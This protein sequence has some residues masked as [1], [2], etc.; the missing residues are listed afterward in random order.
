M[1]LNQ[2]NDKIILV[3]KNNNKIEFEFDVKPTTSF[4]ES[5]NNIII[6]L[7]LN[8]ED[9]EKICEVEEELKKRLNKEIK[10]VILKNTKVGIFKLYKVKNKICCEIKNKKNKNIL[11]TKLNIKKKYKVKLVLDYIWKYKDKFGF[12]WS[13]HH[14]QE[15]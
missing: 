13:I 2:I 11:Y 3:S 14:M 9:K 10:S 5:F 6:Y 1:E 12:S 4:K 8:K 7:E 15:I